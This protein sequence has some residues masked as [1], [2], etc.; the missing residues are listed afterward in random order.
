M[1]LCSRDDTVGLYEVPWAGTVLPVSTRPVVDPLIGQTVAQYTILAKLGGGGMGVVYQARDAKLGRLVALKFLPPQWSHDETAKQR[2]I[3]EAQAASASDHPHICTV[4]DIEST[5]D[6]QLFIVMAY[7]DG[8]TLKQRLESAPLGVDEA[9]Q[10]ATELTDGLAKAHARG[11]VHRDV[12]PGNLMITED[13][14]KILDFGLAKFADA[15]QL[16]IAGSTLGTVAYMS[17]EQARGEEADARSDLWG[18]GVVLYE[19][20][21]GET[22]FKGIYPEA[23]SYAIR[24]DPTPPLKAQERGIPE[25]VEQLVLKALQKHPADR[26]QTA[27]G[28]AREL[29]LVQGLTVPIDLRTETV[30]VQTLAARSTSTRAWRS[31]ALMAGV[32][33]AAAVI[34]GAL[35][36]L[37]P[38]PS[39]PIVVAP[40]LNQTGYPELDPFRL[41]LTHTLTTELGDVR[42]VRV[43]PYGRL[44]DI[45]RRFEAGGADLSSR[46][47]MQ[48]I[49][50]NSGAQIIIVPTLLYENGAWRARAELRMPD[51][52]TS[53]AV[54]DTDPIASSLSKNTAYSLM[55]TLADRLRRHVEEHAPANVR[56]LNMLRGFF[57]GHQPSP[58]PRFSSLE[59]AADF[60]R[61]V[62]QYELLRF[63]EAQQSLTAATLKD[64]QNPLAFAWLGHVAQILQQ[65]GA[66]RQAADQ[67]SRLLV[68]G[69][70]RVDVLFVD[71]VSSESRRDYQTATSRYAELAA[72]GAGDPTWLMEQGAF[73]YRRAL[74]ADA[75]TSYR[76]ALARDSRLP[77]AHL[78]LCRAYNRLSESAR[79][80]QE[81]EA[82]MSGY[83]ALGNRAGEG[84][85]AMCLTD[86]LR[87]GN[88]S[89]RTQSRALADEAVQIFRDAADAYNLARAEASVA[90]AAQA[91]DRPLDALAAYERARTTGAASGNVVL[92]PVLLMNLGAMNLQLGYHTRAL[93]YYQESRS[94][95]E[96]VGDE[97]RAAQDQANVGA[98]LI[99]FAGKPDEGLRDV[100]NA[101]AVFER[102]QDKTYQLFSAK[103][104]A[105][106][107]RYVGRNAESER[108]LNR[109]IALA[110]GWGLS[111]RVPGLTIDRALSRLGIG[112]YTGAR[113]LLTEALGDGSSKDNA[114][115]RLELAATDLKLG[116]FESARVE[117]DQAGKEIR[118]RSQTELLPEWLLTL[119]DLA[120]ESARTAEA[121]KY[122]ADASAL[123]SDE[124]PDPASVSG[125]AQLGLLDVIAG[126]PGGRAMILASLK[127]A[128]ATGP[129]SLQAICRLRLARADFLL[130][131]LDNAVTMAAVTPQDAALDPELR[132]LLHFWHGRALA[133]RGDRAGAALEQTAAKNLIDGI[134]SSLAEADRSSFAFRTEIREILEN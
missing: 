111:G 35:W 133:A 50:A 99:E 118:E 22:P 69:T 66:A 37:K 25:R 7:Y 113:N 106:A 73:Q 109:A 36:L 67:A 6:G 89:D 94:A 43:V 32:V 39:I 60:E 117:L 71:A 3:R 58:A 125:R 38:A 54:Y 92:Q 101:L 102:L 19:M 122:F 34:I 47:A 79:A 62:N 86:Q 65:E 121:R 74:W 55:A 10:I 83:R 72:A 49:A 85:A 110:R 44:L 84:Q 20:L 131:R 59:A 97:L 9:L 45:L 21:T 93:D 123:W 108:E 52:A 26:F 75:V 48:A 64:P 80:K 112:D 4:H 12:K 14:V 104:T 13:G 119:G 107:Y 96:R 29:R 91:Q 40:L 68:P 41:A 17:P 23:I 88:D 124:L 16:T 61:G 98:I 2:F 42:G 51:T 5:D 128:Q 120:I 129:I 82:A 15:L 28:L 24:N 27:R 130:R 56:A 77:R 116:R 127:Q 78:E 76:Q 63:A 18:V 53:A 134:R 46:E 81:G 31:N 95:F 1:E 115:V 57:G 126:S 100:Q 103:V 90:A 114:Y 33:A 8:Q 105:A 70:P 87:L 132:A 30:P 11:I